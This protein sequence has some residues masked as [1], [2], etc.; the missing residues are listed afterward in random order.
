MTQGRHTVGS[1]QVWGFLGQMWYKD[2]EVRHDTMDLG[3]GLIEKEVKPKC[4]S[5]K[6]REG[7]GLDISEIKQFQVKATLKSRC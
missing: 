5:E 7:G 6:R 3:A 2:K 4:S 1:I